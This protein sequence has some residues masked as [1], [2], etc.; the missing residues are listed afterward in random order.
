VVFQCLIITLGIRI[1]Q[2][3]RPAPKGPLLPLKVAEYDDAD[4]GGGFCAIPQQTYTVANKSRT[5]NS[6]LQY[7]FVSV[8]SDLM[9]AD[10][11][12]SS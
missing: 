9:V 12:T 10:K 2:N 6:R 3:K 5:K 1:I 4:I 7:S 11:P 8:A